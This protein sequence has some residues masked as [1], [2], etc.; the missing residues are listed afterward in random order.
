M[1][2]GI[3]RAVPVESAVSASMDLLWSARGRRVG[4]T[5]SLSSGTGSGL[6]GLLA[7][8]L[9]RF[10]EHL[11][12]VPSCVGTCTFAGSTF[13]GSDLVLQPIMPLDLPVKVRSWEL[14]VYPRS[15]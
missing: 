15:H 8:G 1:I 10:A 9:D 6:S 14:T 12:A 3:L 13:A 2:A 11:P 5:V 4:R 7:D